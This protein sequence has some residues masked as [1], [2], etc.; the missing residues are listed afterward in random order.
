MVWNVTI[1]MKIKMI[2]LTSLVSYLVDV[3]FYV[4]GVDSA[5]IVYVYCGIY[6]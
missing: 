5:T 4:T 3:F 2:R 6:I 1:K